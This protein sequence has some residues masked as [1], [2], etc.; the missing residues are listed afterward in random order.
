MQISAIRKKFLEYFASQNH[1]I[2]PSSSLIPHNDPT[3]LFTTAGM[4]QFKDYFIQ[5]I[6]PKHNTVTTSQKCLRAG[7]KHNDLENVGYTA[8][9]HTFFEMLGNFSFGDY[10]KDRAIELAWNLLTKEFSIDPKKLYITIYHDDEQSHNIWKKI[11]GF[12]ES[13]IIKI[14]TS[15]NFWSMGEVGPCGPC[16]EIFY[17]HGEQYFGGLPGTPDEGGDRY[18]EI[19]NLVFMQYEDQLGG[20]RINLPKPSIDTGMGL[21][22]I[23]AVLQ[24]K[25][26][27]Y[28]ID[29]FQKLI[30]ESKNL[31][32]N[33]F[34]SSSHKVIAD[35]MR[36]MCFMMAD[37]IMPLNEGRG[38]VLRRIMRR[39][40]RHY[41]TLGAKDIQL[42][43][44]VPILINEMQEAYP[45]LLRAKATITSI[46]EA[47][48]NRFQETLDRGLKILDAETAN[49]DQ[50]NNNKTLPGEVAFK[51]YDTYGFPLDLTCDILRERGISVDTEKFDAEMVEQKRRARAAWA[52]SGEMATDNVWHQLASDIPASTEFLGYNTHSAQAQVVAII[53]DGSIVKQV[54]SGSAYIILNQTPFYGESGGQVGDTGVIDGNVVKNTTKHLGKF[55]AHHIDNITQP[56]SVGQSVT[57]TIDDNL[58]QAIK[59]NHSATHLLHLA[60]KNILGDHVNQKGSLVTSNRL[61]FDFSHSQALSPAQ[62][63]QVENLVNEMIINNHQVCTKLMQTEEA[64]KQGAMALFGEK[65]GSEVRVVSMGN[66]VELCGGTHANFTGDIGTFKITSEEAVA[67]G[68][69][70]IEAVTGHA[71]LNYINNKEAILKDLASQLKCPEN[72]MV[73]KVVIVI[74]QLKQTEKKLSAL[75][76]HNAI[77]QKPHEYIIKGEAKIYLVK[78]SDINPSDAKNVISHFQKI[79]NSKSIIIISIVTGEKISLNISVSS[80]LVGIDIKAKDLAK[81]LAINLNGNGGGNDNVAQVAGNNPQL[82]DSAIDKLVKKLS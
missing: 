5:T 30:N 52:G 65:Y 77:N 49:L 1:K 66:S 33:D 74:D 4:V 38:Y 45:E 12:T 62:I 8:R 76:I 68:I 46:V 7:G 32:L 56:L 35:H 27:N 70:R 26:N 40:M 14:N 51:L 34:D 37:G 24:G 25:N 18:V 64:I 73:K 79:H 60:L 75:K 44:M 16:S 48:Q 15:D 67:A 23:A 19:W 20:K 42:H 63:A 10:F 82:I 39:A 17:D 36:A 59:A 21:E 31:T 55:H 2:L 81:D 3:L 47:E 9:H 11:T 57:A 72:E 54:D 50:N 58:R 28:D 29:I 80:D 71:A 53:K 69:R 43:K 61:R 13:K 6:L 41:H 22:R 78:L